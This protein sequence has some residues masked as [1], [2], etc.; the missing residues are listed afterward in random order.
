[1]I[2]KLP[3]GSYSIDG[4]A[5]I[6]AVNEALGSQFESEDFDTIGGLVFGVIGRAPEVGDEVH[7]DGNLLTVEEVDGPRVARVVARKEAS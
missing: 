7:L 6:G 3:D 5:S 2:R 1:M 4:S